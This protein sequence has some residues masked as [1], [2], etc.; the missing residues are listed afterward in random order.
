[1]TRTNLERPLAAQVSRSSTDA[2]ALG[3]SSDVPVDAVGPVWINAHGDVDADTF[4]AIAATIA[5]V[6]VAV[7]AERV[8][9][10]GAQT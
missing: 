2:P 4:Q 3:V 6:D 8:A 7:W 1:M 10:A 5:P 9:E